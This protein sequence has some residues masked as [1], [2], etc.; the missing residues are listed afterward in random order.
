[1]AATLYHQTEKKPFTLAHCW[2]ELTGKS[3][4]VSQYD[5]HKNPAKKWKTNDGSCSSIPIGLDEEDGPSE[6]GSGR[7]RMMMGRRWEKDRAARDGAATKMSTTWKDIFSKKE[8]SMHKLKKERE[9]KKAERYD[10]FLALQR[11]RME[12]DR[13]RLK[14]RMDIERARLELVKEEAWMKLQ[15]E[16]KKMA[17]AYAMEQEKVNVARIT[18]EQRIMFQDASLLD[19]PSAKWILMMKKKI[20]DR[21]LGLDGSGGTAP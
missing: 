12:F 3:K 2:L 7:K 5:D 4:W 20:S 11:E 19:E 14:E 8:E 6:T 13:L 17:D 10:A 1:M 18:E 21:D 9:D 16:Q 15:L